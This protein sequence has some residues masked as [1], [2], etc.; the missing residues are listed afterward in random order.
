MTVDKSH[1]IK[2]RVFNEKTID[3]LILLQKY[4]EK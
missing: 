1:P 2:A 4:R 3:I